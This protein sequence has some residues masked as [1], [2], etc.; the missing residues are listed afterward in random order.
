MVTSFEAI[1]LP[2][3]SVDNSRAQ[4]NIP[5]VAEMREGDEEVRKKTE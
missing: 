3:T 4:V 5:Q 1:I 2:I